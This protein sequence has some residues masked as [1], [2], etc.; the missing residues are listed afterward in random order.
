MN[1]EHGIGRLKE[2]TDPW[3][4]IVIG[5]G[6]TGLGCALDAV[7]RG[8]RTALIEQADLGNGTS[9]RSTKLIHGGVRYLRQ[10]NIALVGESLRERGWLMRNAPHLVTP[11]AFLIPTFS[12]LENWYYRCGLGAYDLLAGGLGIHKSRM[13]NAEGAVGKVPTLKSDKLFGGVLY[14]DAQFD[15]AKLCVSCAQTICKN[16]GVTLNYVKGNRLL[17]TNGKVSGI[18]ISD[19]IGGEEISLFGKVIINAT[20]IFSD[21]LRR[22]DAPNTDS[23]IRASRGSHVVVDREFLPNETAIMVPKTSDGRLLFLVPWLGKVILGTTDIPDSN[24]CFEPQP[25]DEEIDFLLGNAAPYLQQ[26]IARADIR[27]VFSGLRPLVQPARVRGKTS[28]ISRDHFIEVSNSGLVTIAG[29][30]WTTFRKMGEDAVDRA[31]QV[32][33]FPHRAS[34]SLHQKIVEIPEKSSRKKLLNERIHP[35]LPYR[36]A[37]VQRAVRQEMAQSV[38]DVLARRTRSLILDA[39][40]AME[41]APAVARHVAAELKRDQAWAESSLESFLAIA[42]NYVIG[43]ANHERTT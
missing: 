10:G 7:S 19:T 4:V 16:G 20:G 40:A 13:Y 21:A 26:P 36:W 17:K 2:E 23:I 27:S 29:G 32:A 31:E 38:D 15:E 14:W 18:E 6:A 9:T 30:K 24:I 5:G 12:R 39:R 28:A 41:A 8:Y 22:Q 43:D 33:G 37:D 1:R 25:T 11:Q 34:Q 3:D 42:K 35:K